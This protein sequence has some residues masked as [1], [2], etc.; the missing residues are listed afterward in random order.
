MYGRFM[1]EEVPVDAFL[2]VA[3][4]RVEV[5]VERVRILT[6]QWASRWNRPPT[7]EELSGLI[8]GWIRDEILYREALDRG[9]DR[10]DELVRRRLIQKMNGV[11]RGLAEGSEPSETDLRSFYLEHLERYVVPARRSFGQVYVSIERGREEAE[12]RAAELIESLPQVSPEEVS[13]LGDPLV[14]PAELTLATTQDVSSRFGPTFA[15]SLFDLPVGGWGGPVHSSFGLHVVK[16][17][18]D[19]PSYTPSFE[20][21]RDKVLVDVGDQRKVAAEA[22]LAAALASEYEIVYA[23]DDADLEIPD[24]G[25]ITR[26]PDVNLLGTLAVL[27]PRKAGSVDVPKRVPLDDQGQVDWRGFFDDLDL[28]G[29]HRD[30]ALAGGDPRRDALIEPAE[31]RLTSGPAYDALTDELARGLRETTK[32]PV[33]VGPAGWIGI[34]CESEPMAGWVIRAL[35]A[36]NIAV[37]REGSTVFLPVSADFTVESEILDMVLAA[38]SALHFFEDHIRVYDHEHE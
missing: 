21:A 27:T 23:W 25:D 2:S 7:N 26:V 8:R 4:R 28:T 35:A 37:R 14:L 24:P 38:A 11:A 19:V 34:T 17:T 6:D 32:T 36:E 15:D 12:L 1:R 9:M 29:S 18:E 33:F 30:I 20:E 16:V 10:D 22:G 13:Q 3:G 31:P 5:T